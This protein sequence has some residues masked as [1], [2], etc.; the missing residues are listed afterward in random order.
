MGEWL[1]GPGARYATGA[2]QHAVTY[3]PARWSAIAPWPRG[4]AERSS[5]AATAISRLQVATTVRDAVARGE[6]LTALV[7]PYV[8]GQGTVGYGPHRLQEILADPATAD[9][10]ALASAALH[11]KGAVAAYGVLDGAVKGLGPAF[12][13][14][15]LYF[16]SL[17]MDPPPTPSP[18]ILDQRVAR[19]LRA[20]AT[21]VGLDLGWEW[22][23]GVAAWIWSDGG[24]SPH[25]YGVYVEWMTAATDQLASAGIGWPE[26]GQDLLEL[27]LFGAAWQPAA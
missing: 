19:V 22:A 24:W 2:G 14:K 25:R 21:R 5:V 27:A 18:L 7:A 20:H 26:A 9:A 6:W 4:L 1:A 10:L 3:V 16:L 8:W 17:A 12:F 11:A 13:T 23:A 15:A